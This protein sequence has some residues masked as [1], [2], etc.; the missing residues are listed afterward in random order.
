MLQQLDPSRACAGPATSV[1]F[2]RSLL[3]VLVLGACSAWAAETTV[4]PPPMPRA[5]PAERIITKVVAGIISRNHYSQH[6]LDDQIAKQLFEDYFQKLDSNHSFFLASDIEEFRSYELILDDLLLQGNIDFAF[7]VYA[8]FLQ[9]VRERVE[10]CRKRLQEPFDFNVEEFLEVDRTKQPWCKT[11][12]EMDELWRKRLKNKLLIYDIMGETAAVTQEEDLDVPVQRETEPKDKEP[13]PTA[14]SPQAPLPDSAAQPQPAPGAAVQPAPTTGDVPTPAPT[15]GTEGPTVTT[16]PGT[17]AAAAKPTETPSERTLKSFETYLHQVESRESIDVLEIYLSALTGV[18]DPHSSYMAPNTEEDFDISMKLSLEG[19]GALLSVDDGYVKVAGVLPGGPAEF[20]GRLKEGDRILQVRQEKEDEPVDIVDTPLRK[21]VKLIRGTKGTRVYLTIWEAG[22]PFGSVPVIIDL[23]RDEVKLTEQEAKMET[24]SVP[25]PATAQDAKPDPSTIARVATISL[26]SFYADFTA[27]NKGQDEYKSSTRDTHQL[28]D[29]AAKD[30]PVDGLVLDLRGNGGGSLEE[31]VTLAGLFFGKGPVV[32]VRKAGGS[33]QRR[34]DPDESEAY[35]G[36]LIILVDRLSA[37]ASEILAAAIQDHHRGVIV[38]EQQT[39]GKGT[40]QT[41]Y[42]LDQKLQRNSALKDIKAGSLKFTMAK[43]YRVSGGSTQV[44]GVTPDIVFPAF[45]DYLE[46]GESHLPHALPWDDIAP[47]AVERDVDVEPFLPK[48]KE[49][50]Q[51]RVNLDPE[52]QKLIPM[53]KEFGE[54]RKRTEQPLRK[55]DR[56]QLQKQ[57]D[58]W[59]KRIKDLGNRRT[60][61]HLSGKS[62]DT[63]TP[64]NDPVLNEACR[65]LADLI[66]LQRGQALPTTVAAS[67]ATTGFARPTAEGV[68][69][70]AE[71]AIP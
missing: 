28:I 6:N 4:T 1:K 3:A 18:Y 16:L 67:E 68:R 5:T 21:A 24:L 69:E 50:S 40:V 46:L 8:R 35:G 17:T 33:I 36:P 59:S 27:K 71:K 34:D 32:Q 25:L 26:P 44:R 30:G 19:I 31:A 48:L 41:V 49:R 47:L 56:I 7:D 15:A 61:K 9:R 38:G 12:E 42:H 20:D 53:F 2:C 22:K 10:Y 11:Q 43:F 54:Q 37:S 29:Q 70:T 60:R 63:E 23:V 39:H 62:K 45:T 66:V 14:Q 13:A 57:E 65:I 51:A 58:E 55:E 64:A 52:F